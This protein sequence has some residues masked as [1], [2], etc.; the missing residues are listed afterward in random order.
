MTVASLMPVSLPGSSTSMF[1]ASGRTMGKSDRSS[2]RIVPSD[3]R[4]LGERVASYLR[5]KHPEKTALY[6]ASEIGI[7]AETVRKWLEQ[8]SVPNGAA[9]LALIRR[10][11]MSFVDGVLGE[12]ADDWITDLARQEE[13]E[14]LE[15]EAAAIRQ[16]LAFVM[17][18]RL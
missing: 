15:A 12:D 2:G 17:G 18:G 4:T 1:T 3:G 9:M 6:V 5:A 14:R 8:G 10:Y 7:S 16:K 11:R 13:Q